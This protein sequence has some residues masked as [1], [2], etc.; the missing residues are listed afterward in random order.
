LW[1]I[2]I[3]GLRA[4]FWKFLCPCQLLIN[5]NYVFEVCFK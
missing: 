2:C 5:V 3:Q 1:N 4:V